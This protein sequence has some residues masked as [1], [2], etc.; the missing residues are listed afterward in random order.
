MELFQLKNFPFTKSQRYVYVTL[1]RIFFKFKIKFG[2]QNGSSMD[3]TILKR[4]GDIISVQYTHIFLALKIFTW[5]IYVTLSRIERYDRPWN[6]D[7][8]WSD[9]QKEESPMWSI[10]QSC[11]HQREQEK[12][13]I[14]CLKWRILWINTDSVII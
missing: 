8:M 7:W 1:S 4:N 10:F 3:P 9:N 11:E 13:H 14:C 6:H 2:L 5:Y 12:N